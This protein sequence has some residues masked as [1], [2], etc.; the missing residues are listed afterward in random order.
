[1]NLIAGC[2]Y[3]LAYNMLCLWNLILV[4]TSILNRVLP[5]LLDILWEC[6]FIHKIIFPQICT[7]Y[8]FIC[9]IYKSYVNNAE[10]KIFQKY[11]LL[12]YYFFLCD[13]NECTLTF[14]NWLEFTVVCVTE[15]L[16]FF[17][18]CSCLLL[19]KIIVLDF[20]SSGA[21]DFAFQYRGWGFDPF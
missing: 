11:F 20:K 12:C 17:N 9:Q 8:P 13:R 14:P 10:W 7:I 4:P 5:H 19:D 2:F 16:F 18:I 15:F 21:G 1:M 6:G 3:F